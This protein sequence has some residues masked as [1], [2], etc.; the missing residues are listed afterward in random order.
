MTF[1][2]KQQNA[3][4]RARHNK[5]LHLEHKMFMERLKQERD[6]R[7]KVESGAAIHI[8]KVAR[9]FLVRP[10]TSFVS[11]LKETRSANKLL[12]NSKAHLTQDLLEMTERVG[13][14]PIPGLTLNSRKMMEREKQEQEEKCIQDMEAAS[15]QVRWSE[16]SEFSE[17]GEHSDLQEDY[18]A[19]SPSNASLYDKLTPL[20][21]RFA[22]RSFN[23]YLG[24]DWEG[25]R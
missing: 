25:R 14:Q 22:R 8:Q 2:E 1:L 5:E 18:M 19:C 13:L 6:E 11:A 10:R 16:G 17:C 3:K 20:T 7:V 23:R 21:H 15:V 24:L 4:S 12:M 9:G